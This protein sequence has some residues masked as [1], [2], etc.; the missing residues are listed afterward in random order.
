MLTQPV[1]DLEKIVR[2][3][4]RTIAP[5]IRAGITIEKS[6]NSRSVEVNYERTWVDSEIGLPFFRWR[7]S[8]QE[9]T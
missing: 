2:E 5:K 4:L 1:D 9:Q 6:Y 7:I 8:R 3:E